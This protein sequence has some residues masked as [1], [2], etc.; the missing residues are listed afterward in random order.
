MIL[1][2]VT[3]DWFIRF[4]TLKD[5]DNVYSKDRAY[6]FERQLGLNTR[7]LLTKRIRDYKLPEEEAIIP[8]MI[9]SPTIVN[10]GRRLLI[11]SQPI[12]YLTKDRG[13]NVISSNIPEDI[14][15]SKLFAD[16]GADN[17]LFSS[18]LRMNATFPYIFPMT[19]LPSD[20][21]M[22]IMD[23]GI[24]DNFGMKTTARFLHTFRNWINT[25]TSGVVIVQ[26]RDLPKNLD[27]SDGQP[28]AFNQLTA[29]LGSIYGNMT[30][31]HDYNNDQLFEYM[32]GSFSQPIDLITFELQQTKEDHVSLSWHLTEAEKRHIR[33]ATAHTYFKQELER[34]QLL[35]NAR[36]EMVGE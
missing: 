7:Q 30:K 22:E 23:A 27:L 12:S 24:R 17:L 2:L 13:D 15:F 11:A 4:Q 21:P 9:L 26:V 14:E 1:S 25:N 29:P 5:G 33:K 35:L 19:T 18:A 28:G 3:N 8:M 6:A 16:Q 34:L 31:T 10:D 32:K 20:P 36:E